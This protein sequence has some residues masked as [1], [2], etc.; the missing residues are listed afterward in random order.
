MALVNAFIV[1]RLYRKQ[2]NKR[3]MKHYAFFEML[4][5]QLLA[6]DEDTFVEIEVS[7]SNTSKRAHGTI[8]RK[9]RFDATGC[10]KCSRYGIR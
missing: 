5:E 7:G 3:P 2:I 9:D 10:C 6:L 8:T 1:H 4:M